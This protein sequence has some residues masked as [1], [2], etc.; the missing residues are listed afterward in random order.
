MITVL[1]PG[2]SVSFDDSLTTSHIT[3]H[4]HS[5]SE[6]V[7]LVLGYV[8]SGVLWNSLRIS[9][10]TDS[11]HSHCTNKRSALG[12]WLCGGIE[13]SHGH[14]HWPVG[15]GYLY[16]NDRNCHN[17]LVPCARR[18]SKL[19]RCSFSF[20]LSCSTMSWFLGL[21]DSFLKRSPGTNKEPFVETLEVD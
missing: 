1:V 15:T 21:Q 10:P 11:S 7:C 14:K 13:E 4:L 2:L 3:P 5:S 17:T 19:S 20:S 12:F 16:S 9:C 6:G 18:P 8:A